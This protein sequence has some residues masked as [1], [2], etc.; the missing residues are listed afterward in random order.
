MCKWVRGV[1]GCDPARD[2]WGS[3]LAPHLAAGQAG[4]VMTATEGKEQFG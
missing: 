2:L 4:H 3:A 1:I